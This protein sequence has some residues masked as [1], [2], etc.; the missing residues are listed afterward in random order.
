M[1]DWPEDELKLIA[2]ADDLHIAPFRD[3]GVT[4]GT[5]T[6]IWSVVVDGALYARAYNGRR[7]RWYQAAVKQK[8]GCI[9]T[10][11]MTKEVRFDPVKGEVNDLVDEAY[12][13]K[14]RTSQYLKPMLGDR[15]KAATVRII[16]RNDGVLGAPHW[17]IS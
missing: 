3:D 11:R 10:A 14:Y 13:A 15:A 6:W 4:L 2:D 17:V 1:A 12:R 5:P 16:P 7:S 8:A 9:T